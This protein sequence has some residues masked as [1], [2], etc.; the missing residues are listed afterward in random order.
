MCGPAG[1]MFC[2]F[3]S[4]FGVFF[5]GAMAIL[6]GNDY[7]Y[8]GEWYDATTG[9]PYSEQKANALHNLWMVTGVWG[10]FAVVSLIGTCYHTFKKRV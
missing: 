7:Q 4:I 9:E 10:G 2:L 1:T 5:M 6:I 3:I 8:V